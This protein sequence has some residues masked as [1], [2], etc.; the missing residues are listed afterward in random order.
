MM[1]LVGPPAVISRTALKQ[2]NVKSV[3][4]CS[5]GYSFGSCLIVQLE[6]N[7]KHESGHAQQNAKS[8]HTGSGDGIV[9][10]SV[11]A[12]IRSSRVV[13]VSFTD[14]AIVVIIIEIEALT[15][16]SCLIQTFS[17]AL[18]GCLDTAVVA[19]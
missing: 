16:V 14:I 2:G 3:N 17:V 7:V 12:I 6:K 18:V 8:V 9:G 13:V 4:F 11:V 19:I 5:P 15:I 1:S 10:S